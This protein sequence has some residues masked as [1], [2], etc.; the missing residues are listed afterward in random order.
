MS[1]TQ[2]KAVLASGKVDRR[3]ACRHPRE[4]IATHHPG[5]PESGQKPKWPPVYFYWSHRLPFL[6]SV[7]WHEW[8]LSA[9]ASTPFHQ[10]RFRPPSES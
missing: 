8:Q 3:L 1:K 9:F 2:I 6:D 5:N 7:E 10:D 4:S